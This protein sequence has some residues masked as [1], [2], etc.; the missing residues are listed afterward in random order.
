VLGEG[1]PG[2]RQLSLV[3]DVGR[4]D[5]DGGELAEVEQGGQALGVELVG[6]V[7]VAHHD[8]GLGCVSQEGNA[9]SLLDLIDDPVP[10]AHGLQSDGRALGEL[11][12]EGDDSAGNMAHPGALDEVPASVQDRE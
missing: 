10:V 5:P 7:D 3:P 2:A 1:H 12:E 9:A 6:L 4:G 8:L 11:G